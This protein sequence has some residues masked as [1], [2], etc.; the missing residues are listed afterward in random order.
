MN[1]YRMDGRISNIWEFNFI[2]T[3]FFSLH[4]TSVHV[5]LNIREVVSSFKEEVGNHFSQG[6]PMRNWDCGQK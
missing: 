4:F 2:K 6:D 3:S 1:D 5:S